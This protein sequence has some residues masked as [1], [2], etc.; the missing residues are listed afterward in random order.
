MQPFFRYPG[1][2]ALG[3][4]VLLFLNQS[5]DQALVAAGYARFLFANSKDL[6]FAAG[7]FKGPDQPI[8]DALMLVF[9]VVGIII[10]YRRFRALQP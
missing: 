5:F 4:L 8:G 9:A 1:R 6:V 3:F 2:P 10:L 7:I